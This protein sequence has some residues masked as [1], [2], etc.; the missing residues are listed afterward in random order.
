[1]AN[2]KALRNISN[3]PLE[4]CFDGSAER[5]APGQTG[6]FHTATEW[7]S[8]AQKQADVFVNRHEARYVERDATKVAENEL[9]LKPQEAKAEPQGA[10]EQ[11]TTNKN[12][13]KG[14]K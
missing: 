9:Y 13:K 8:L 12:T 7:D 14:D 2:V 4:L 5:I 1:M 11:P 10:V 3:R 6:K